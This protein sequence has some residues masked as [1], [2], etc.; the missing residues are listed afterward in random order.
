M[1]AGR[2]GRGIAHAF[3]YGGHPVTIVDF[4]DRARA[5]FDRLAIE[6]KAEIEG[7]LIALAREEVFPHALVADILAL[8]RVVPL[9]DAA[10]AF[11]N[12]ELVWEGVPERMDAKAD[13]LGRV[14]AMI[15]PDAIVA[16]TTSTLPVTELQRHVA[17]PDRFL[18]AHF[19][20]PAFLIPLVEVSPG[21]A[22]DDAVTRRLIT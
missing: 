1:G 17:R 19:L 6:A 16:S 20:N 15:A 9:K 4:K 14:S 3:A 13:A 8:I 22:T 12:A 5:D 21:P 7:N 10:A 11:G 18:N 2:M